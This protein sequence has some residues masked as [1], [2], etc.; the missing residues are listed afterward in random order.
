VKIEIGARTDRGRVRE[1]NEDNYKIDADLKLFVLSDGMGGVEHGEIAASIA[2]ESIVDYC[3]SARNDSQIT[4]YG[5]SQ[6]HLSKQTN[7]LVSAIQFANSKIF[8]AASQN[9]EKHGMGATVVGIWLDR[10]RL[11]IAHVGDSRLYL[12]R[13]GS[14]SQV[15]SDH[16]LVAE[17]VRQG[18]MTQMEADHSPLQNVLTRA[19]GTQPYVEVEGQ[20]KDLLAGDVLLLCSDGLSKMI[21]DSEIAATFRAQSAAQDAA[22]SLINKANQNGG[23]DNVTAIVVRAD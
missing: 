8:E 21:T 12:L 22:D 5:R 4:S 1:N 23:Y 16:S 6:D 18:V 20:E 15:T 13:S 7:R 2:V 11:S 9:P 17:Q 10:A 19:L 14:L 3:R